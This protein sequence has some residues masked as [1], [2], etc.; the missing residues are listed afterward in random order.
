MSTADGQVGA[1]EKIID[2]GA[3]ELRWNLVLLA[4]GYR[5]VE[6]PLFAQHAQDFATTLLATP[7]FDKLK[8]AINLFRVNVSSTDSGADDPIAC[9]GP[10]VVARTYF[11]ASFCNDGIER[12]LEVDTAAALQ[13]AGQVVPQYAMVLVMVNSPTYGGSGGSVAVFSQAVGA[14]EIALHEMGHTAFGLADEYE[15]WA[16]CGVD[17]DHDHHQPFEPAYPNVTININPQT[18]KWRD[19]LTTQRLPTTENADCSKCDPQ[20]S[21]VPSGT[22]GAFEGAHYYHCGAYRPEYNCRMRQLGQP[23]C[24]VCRKRITETLASHLPIVP[25][26][27]SGTGGR[28]C[29]LTLPSLALSV[30]SLVR[31]ALGRR[32]IRQAPTA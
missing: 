15:S 1:T 22:V 8:S 32:G 3:N 4:D 27:A 5:A 2:N 30:P 21:P 11:D 29:L 17:T 9:G 23:Y 10:G 31:D 28:G 12:L 26:P 25:Q 24:G 13:L 14:N 19:L 20:P 18:I 6:L 16:G 7:P